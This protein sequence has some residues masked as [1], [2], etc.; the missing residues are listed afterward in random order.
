MEASLL[1]V[2]AEIAYATAEGQAGD[3]D[4]VSGEGDDAEASRTGGAGG[5][6]VAFELVSALLARSDNA[7]ELTQRA[8]VLLSQIYRDRGD[9]EAC[10]GGLRKANAALSTAVT[11]RRL[12][13][14]CA[15]YAPSATKA[16][17]KRALFKEARSNY[18][19]LCALP[20]PAPGDRINLA[21]VL[22]SL[23]E[24]L[25]SERMLKALLDEGI[26]DYRVAMNLAFLYETTG[27]DDDARSFGARAR[28]A[29]DN[30]PA[31]SREPRD[32]ANV[33]ALDKLL[34]RLG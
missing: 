14:A 27:E 24:Y 2:R 28:R 21:I 18:E 4:G 33:Q 1:L 20:V 9:W 7:P 25:A 10:I 12:A 13:D 34:K 11:L 23:G 32:S 26:D 5:G 30:T 29:Y 17:E 19:A 6:Q 22:R 3:R 8:Y 31:Q 16:E 15:L